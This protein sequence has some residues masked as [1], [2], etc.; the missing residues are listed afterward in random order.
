M[1]ETGRGATFVGT[2]NPENMCLPASMRI[3]AFFYPVLDPGP[4]P[5]FVQSYKI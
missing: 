3:A 2:R 1:G 4:D 5:I